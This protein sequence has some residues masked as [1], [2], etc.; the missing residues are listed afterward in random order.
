LFLHVWIGVGQRLMI[1]GV[2]K[3][4]RFVTI[5][6]SSVSVNNFGRLGS[7]VSIF[8]R[9]AGLFGSSLLVQTAL[10]PSPL[11]L[12]FA[13]TLGGSMMVLARAGTGSSDSLDVGWS[14]H[15]GKSCLCV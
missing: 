12:R 13:A 5:F 6:S 15:G 3:F 4:C 14:K 1:F 8:G 9:A 10:S 7:S 2:L 11:S